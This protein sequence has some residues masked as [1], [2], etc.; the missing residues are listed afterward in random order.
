[1]DIRGMKGTLAGAL[2]LLSVAFKAD[3][4]RT[5]ITKAARLML[6]TSILLFGEEHRNVEHARNFT[7][8]LRAA[9]LERPGRVGLVA[10]EIYDVYQ[11]RIDRF[12]QDGDEKELGGTPEDEI[13]R[14][15]KDSWKTIAAFRDL[16]LELRRIRKA[17][18]L[19]GSPMKVLAIDHK[20]DPA[21]S[22]NQWRKK[23]S[24]LEFVLWVLGRDEF[25]FKTIEPV[26][27]EVLERQQTAL[28]LIGSA[29]A[30]RSGRMIVKAGDE[31]IPVIFLATRLEERFPG[32]RTIA[33]NDPSNECVDLIER[34][35]G[36]AATRLIDLRSS[37]LGA[38]E[39]FRCQ[40]ELPLPHRF[41]PAPYRAKD[42]YDYYWFYSRLNK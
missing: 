9:E 18:G 22:L 33:Q 6:E 28:V 17:R 1:M 3:A 15:H 26:L 23:V 32:T 19:A 25:M 24:K 29:H 16:L 36:R 38:L 37:L 13:L 11:E 40:D 21:L 10:L 31:E 41:E 14:G 5:D 34:K 8:A 4:Q 7:L 12:L 27:R 39:N 30:Q 20:P 2:L 42:H 35:A